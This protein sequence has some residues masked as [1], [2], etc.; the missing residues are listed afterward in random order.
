MVGESRCSCKEK[1]RL[2]GG[3]ELNKTSVFVRACQWQLAL[4]PPL[5]QVEQMALQ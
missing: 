1:Q 2:V 3:A 4:A 5:P